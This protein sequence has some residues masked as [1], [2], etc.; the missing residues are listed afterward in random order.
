MNEGVNHPSPTKPVGQSS[1][2]DTCREHCNKRLAVMKGQ[3]QPYEAEAKEVASLAQPA[4]SRFMNSLGTRSK[5]ERATNRKLQDDHGILAFRTLRNGMTSGLSSGSRPW[6]KV[7]TA[8]PDLMKDSESAEWLTQLESEIYA[9]ARR[10]GF[11]PVAANGYAE[12][13]LFGIEAGFMEESWRYDGVCHSM[14]FGEYWTAL[15]AEGR[16]DTLYRR[17]PMT[18]SQVVEKF[19]RKRNGDMDWSRVSSIVKSA[20]DRSNY[21]LGINVMHAVE[22]NFDQKHGRLDAKGMPFKSVWWDEGDD[23]K[24]IVLREGGYEEQPFWSPRW[25]TVGGDVYASSYPG[26]DCLAS[27][28]QLQMQA[29]RKGEA[30]DHAILPEVM[31]PASL[32]GMV[33]RQPRNVVYAAQADMDKISPTYQVDYRAIGVIREDIADIRQSIDRLSYS[34]L[35]MAITNMRG[36]QPRNMEEIASRNEESLQQLGPTI[37]RVEVEKLQV[38]IDRAVGIL[39]RAG[40]LRPAP[41]ALEGQ[42]LQF[43]FI[44]ILA[45]MQRMVGIG[46]IERSVS[47]VGNMAAAWPDALDNVDSDATVREYFD[48]AGSPAITLR[49]EKEVEAIRANRAKEMAEAKAMQAAPAM[50]DGAEAARLLSEADTG[51]G[52]SLLAS[53]TGMG[54]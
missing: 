19:V 4:R 33:K 7:E 47:F 32:R 27:L 10:S 11:Y 54:V 2:N 16:P 34:E 3:R 28:R 12:M 35:F 52:Q 36:I 44:S 6:I 31:A 22:P 40:R 20:W 23:R 43:T 25:E 41:E 46:Q 53:L 21:D 26:V 1:G 18:A 5:P 38:W 45:Q 49:S 42:P 30:T 17:V 15:N 13:G 24:G 51:N 8:D 14:T 50:R 39:H 9:L 29:K 48:R 37:E